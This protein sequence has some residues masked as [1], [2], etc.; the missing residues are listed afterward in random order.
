M[1]TSQ[2]SASGATDE[3]VGAAAS[4]D[5]TPGSSTPGGKGFVFAANTAPTAAQAAKTTVHTTILVKRRTDATLPRCGGTEPAPTADDVR[6]SH[7]ARTR[8]RDHRP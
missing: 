3:V 5:R 8:P 2:V 1:R 6:H 4:V 7:E